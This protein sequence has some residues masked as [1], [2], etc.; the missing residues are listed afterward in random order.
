MDE[1]LEEYRAK[2]RRQATVNAVK[3]K[4]LNMVSFQ[5]KSDLKDQHIIN[6]EVKFDFLP[7]LKITF[8]IT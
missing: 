6:T 3:D 8:K 1:K 5:G 7:A 4:V 2:K